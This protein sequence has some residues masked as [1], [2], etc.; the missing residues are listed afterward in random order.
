ATARAPADDA[1][2]IYDEAFRALVEG[3]RADARRLVDGLAARADGHPATARARELLRLWPSGVPSTNVATPTDVASDETPENP[4]EAEDESPSHEEKRTQLSRAGLAAFATLGGI[5]VG[6]EL[7]AAV[8]CSSGDAVLELSFLVGGSSLAAALVSTPNG[9]RPGTAAALESGFLW[10]AWNAVALDEVKGVTLER[11]MAYLMLGEGLGIGL[12][13]VASATARPTAGQVSLAT[14]VGLWTGVLTWFGR[15]ARDL[16]T[17]DD[18]SFAAMATTSDLGLAAGSL[19]AAGF[20]LSRG[21]ALMIDAGGMGG[22]LAGLGVVAIIGG[23]GTR[24][25]TYYKALV[26]STLAGLA[27]AAY[28]TRDWEVPSLPVSVAIAPSPGG[29]ATAFVGGRF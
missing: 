20:P 19:L 6:A 23:S 18:V 15:G 26:P 10:G 27:A 22:A 14:T 12:G 29:G 3:R 9:V 13:G 7:C 16:P 4:E 1:W 21:H 8:S 25:T 2:R 28:F 17:T 11:G 24:W 5:A